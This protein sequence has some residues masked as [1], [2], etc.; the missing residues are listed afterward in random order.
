MSNYSPASAFGASDIGTVLSLLGSDAIRGILSSGFA[1]PLRMAVT[2]LS[3]AGAVFTLIE[4]FKMGVGL[5]IA[6]RFGFNIDDDHPMR[7]RLDYWWEKTNALTEQSNLLQFYRSISADIDHE[8]ILMLKRGRP[9]ISSYLMGLAAVGVLLAYAIP[10][11]INICFIPTADIA[12]KI[13]VVVAMILLAASLAVL[14]LLC[15]YG[16]SIEVRGGN[17]NIRQNYAMRSCEDWNLRSIGKIQLP[18]TVGRNG[19]G[20]GLHLV[21]TSVACKWT[22]VFLSVISSICLVYLLGR[23]GSLSQTRVSWTWAIWFVVTA[24]ARGLAWFLTSKN[25]RELRTE[26]ILGLF[27]RKKAHNNSILA[28]SPFESFLD[29]CMGPEM[30]EKGVLVQYD[31]AALVGIEVGSKGFHYVFSI[32]GVP[33]S[34]SECVFD[35]RDILSLLRDGDDPRLFLEGGKLFV[36]MQQMA[37]TLQSRRVGLARLLL[38]YAASS[39]ITEAFH[40]WQLVV[41]LINTAGCRTALGFPFDRCVENRADLEILLGPLYAAEKDKQAAL[42]KALL[43]SSGFA[44][45]YLCYGYSIRPQTTWL[46][47]QLAVSWL[48]ELTYESLG[49]KGVKYTDI[50]VSVTSARSHCRI[51]REWISNEILGAPTA[52]RTAVAGVGSQPSIPGILDPMEEMILQA[53]RCGNRGL[54]TV[55]PGNYR[56]T[57][58]SPVDRVDQLIALGDSPWDNSRQYPGICWFC[59]VPETARPTVAD[60]APP[61]TILE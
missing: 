34:L 23:M 28:V 12:L 49:L 7:E 29:W 15:F 16:Q 39:P 21:W 1:N 56:V 53:G 51:F 35:T 9:K 17:P 6:R 10:V 8:E 48:P 52:V 46:T 50:G 59:D 27:E 5:R 61:A 54:F 58:S 30:A 45:D 31:R 41:Y 11:A 26:L 32:A 38:V 13:S 36:P 4:Y 19:S 43:V 25:E 47:A 14:P 33:S 40:L 60:L 3:P 2:G 20:L 55:Q 57:I 37:S 22:V 18:E 24:F 42:V 44:T